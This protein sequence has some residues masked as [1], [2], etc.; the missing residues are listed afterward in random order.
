MIQIKIIR[1]YHPS[2]QYLKGEKIWRK[3]N[4]KYMLLVNMDCVWTSVTDFFAI[5]LILTNKKK[6]IKVSSWEHISD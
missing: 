1:L 4:I 3:K 5:N 2:I 6:I